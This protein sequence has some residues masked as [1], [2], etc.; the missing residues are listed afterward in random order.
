MSLA[1]SNS[2]Y[3]QFSFR[4]LW[5]GSARN[6]PQMDFDLAPISTP[7]PPHCLRAQLVPTFADTGA[8]GIRTVATWERLPQNKWAGFQTLPPE[9]VLVNLPAQQRFSTSSVANPHPH[10]PARTC[11]KIIRAGKVATAGRQISPPVKASS[12]RI[13]TLLGRSAYCGFI[14]RLLHFAA[15]VVLGLKGNWTNMYTARLQASFRALAISRV[16]L[17]VLATVGLLLGFLLT[18]ALRLP[19]S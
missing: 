16:R 2:R 1:S 6:P 13:T 18:L 3:G 5:S 4:L 19:V 7:T 14:P 9:S 15:L 11:P 10:S 17:A 12:G 8:D